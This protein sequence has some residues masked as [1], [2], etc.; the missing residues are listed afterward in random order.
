MNLVEPNH[1]ML[2]ACREAA[3]RLKKPQPCTIIVRTP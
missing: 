1:A 3:A 2:T